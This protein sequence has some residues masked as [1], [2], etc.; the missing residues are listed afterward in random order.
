MQFWEWKE[1]GNEPVSGSASDSPLSYL[2]HPVQYSHSFTLCWKQ[3][4]NGFLHHTCLCVQRGE[5][6][7]EHPILLLWAQISSVHSNL[8]WW[9]SAAGILPSFGAH[10]TETF[11]FSV[12]LSNYWAGREGDKIFTLYLATCWINVVIL[13]HVCA[14]LTAPDLPQIK[15]ETLSGLKEMTT[16]EQLWQLSG[17]CRN[18]GTVM[19][20]W[21]YTTLWLPAPC[22]LH[23]LLFLWNWKYHS[24]PGEHPLLVLKV[25]Y[26]QK[27]PKSFIWGK[28]QHLLR[29]KNFPAYFL[30]VSFLLSSSSANAA[31]FKSRIGLRGKGRSDWVA[32]ESSPREYG[33]GSHTTAKPILGAEHQDQTSE[34]YLAWGC[35]CLFLFCF[36]Q[37]QKSVFPVDFVCV[38]FISDK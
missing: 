33:W 37:S 26:S 23:A 32:V 2:T 34:T 36:L 9:L 8:T 22:A 1:E 4:G 15:Q 29:K 28:F 6:A 14:P 21:W 7:A 30:A 10:T 25:T 27:K 31:S 16:A 12:S 5:G 38:E 3:T 17:M 19:L 35:C 18:G 13:G 11:V 24:Y 20:T